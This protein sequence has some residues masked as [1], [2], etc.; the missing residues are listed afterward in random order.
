MY[1]RASRNMLH[2]HRVDTIDP[3]TGNMIGMDDAGDILASV[4]AMPD[5]EL[6]SE[7]DR[8]LHENRRWLAEQQAARA[9]DDA[10]RV[11][12]IGAT[13]QTIQS[14][15]S[16]VKAEAKR[17]NIAR[18]DREDVEFKRLLRAEIGDERFFALQEQARVS[19]AA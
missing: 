8:L 5:A 7:R 16:V 12:G 1:K 3:T 10:R 11:L 2:A 4:E 6:E 14:R 18:S 13:L 9:L 17:R 19:A 15:M